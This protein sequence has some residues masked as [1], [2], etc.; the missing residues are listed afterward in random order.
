MRITDD[1]RIIDY[2]GKG[3]S[4]KRRAQL[5]DIALD[6]SFDRSTLSNEEKRYIE[7]LE[8]GESDGESV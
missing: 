8:K 2:P 4:E 3:L 6:E 5:I 7:F 1:I